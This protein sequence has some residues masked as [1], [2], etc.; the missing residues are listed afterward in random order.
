MNTVAKGL[1]CSLRLILFLLHLVLGLVL[2]AAFRVRHGEQWH[3]CRGGQRLI[4]WWMKNLGRVLGLRIQASGPIQPAPILLV[5]NHVSWLDIVAVDAI[6]PTSFVAKSSVR[7]WPV[8]G[9]LAALS[10]TRF[11]A[12]ERTS[13]IYAVIE[14]LSEQLRNGA[15]VGLFPEGTSSDGKQV[16]W[17]HTALFQSAVKAACPIQTVAIQYQRNGQLDTI[18]PFIDDDNFVTHLLRVLAAPSTTVRLSF[19]TVAADDNRRKLAAACYQQIQQAL[20]GPAA[21]SAI[22]GPSQTGRHADRQPQ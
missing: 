10:G 15:R 12:R 11:L 13:R 21:D 4:Q 6:C 14:D 19:D 3:Q 20:Y 2:T 5:A 8:I 18:A 1:R 17:F 16:G 9:Y 7:T 22:P